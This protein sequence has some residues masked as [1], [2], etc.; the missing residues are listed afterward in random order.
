[1]NIKTEEKEKKLFLSWNIG[2][3]RM[4]DF[5]NKNI[6]YIIEIKGDNK[7]STYESSKTNITIENI[8]Y[9]IDYEI[10]IKALIEENCGNWSEIKK[11]KFKEP[12]NNYGLFG[13]QYNNNIFG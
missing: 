2:D 12:Q 7:I 9:N 6:K 1:M 11:S 13:N 8:K 5:D 3:F 4:K 10:K